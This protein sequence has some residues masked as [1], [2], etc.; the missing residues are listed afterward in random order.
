M[1]HISRYQ[2]WTTGGSALLGLGLGLLIGQQS[3]PSDITDSNL[4][5]KQLSS[6]VSLRSE[7]SE[8]SLN[9]NFSLQQL[10]RAPSQSSTNLTT[11]DQLADIIN[12]SDKLERTRLL[13]SL[14]DTLAPH[15]YERY[16]TAFRDQGWMQSNS[17]EFDFLLAGW[18]KQAP[19]AAISYLS[20]H[21]PNGLARRGA[22][23]SWATENPEAAASAIADLEDGGR[24][25]DWVIGLIHGIARNDPESALLTLQTLPKNET[26]RTAMKNIIP[27]VVSRGPE[28]ANQWIEMVDDPSMQSFAA[29]NIARPLAQRDPEAA[30]EWIRQI[31]TTDTRRDASEV[32]SEVFAA[33]DLE[34]ATKWAESLPPDTR[35]EAAEGVAKHMTRK[36]PAEAARWL[37][38][39]GNDPDLDG[40]RIQFLREASRK[41]PEI[42]LD[43]VNTLSEPAQQERYYRDILRTWSK[44]NEEAAISWA[45]ENSGAISVRVY[46]SIVPKDRRKF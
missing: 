45:N 14:I 35:S 41:D 12:T 40:A 2:L 1:K 38:K 28:F 10:D 24:V 37:Q 5:Q 33:N 44:T 32:V 43:Q 18:M 9:E 21:E 26:L 39:L 13:L 36:D 17:Q 25:N 8:N 27:D 7:N 20:E 30:S 29:K 15:D 23:S 46:R 11:P 34:A 31:K 42:A 22:I 3:Q 19:L 6:R 16:V 4:N